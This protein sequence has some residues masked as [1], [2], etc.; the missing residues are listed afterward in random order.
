MAVNTVFNAIDKI[1]PAFGKMQTG[2]GRFS[3]AA[4]AAFRS[5][6]PEASRLND[7]IKGVTF[8]NLLS[9]GIA[10][11]VNLIRNNIK[12]A[13]GYASD[14]IEVQN[15]VDTVFGKSANV[16]DDF[17]KKAGKSFGLTELQAKKF[18]SNFGA[19]LSG[20]G[21][22]DK[23]A[24]DMSVNLTG[25]AGDLSSFFNLDAADAYS[26]L[27][28]GLMGKAQPLQSI[29]I[30]VSATSMEEFAK[31]QGLVWKS[32]D[33]ANQTML[34]YQFIMEKT[35]LA[36]GDYQKP[37]ASW[38]VSSRNATQAI[39]EMAGKLAVGFM[40]T[41]IKLADLV[42]DI[43]QKISDWADENKKFIAKKF[44]YYVNKL[45]TFTK[46]LVKITIKFGP[47]VLAAV[48]AV[49][50]FSKAKAI[51]QGVMVAVQAYNAELEAQKLATA[52]ATAAQH[53]LNT[54]MKANIIGLIVAGVV[55][56]IGLFI[57]LSQKVGGVKNAFIVV[58]QTFMK[59]ILTPFNFWIEVFQLLLPLG[60][61]IGIILSES[62][63]AVGQTVWKFLLTPLNLVISSIS[64]LLGAVGKIPGATW[65]KD[66]SNGIKTFQNSMN[67]LLTG[68][69]STLFNSGL[70]AFLDPA[71]GAKNSM[72]GKIQAAEALAT[73]GVSGIE[74]FQ[75]KMN[76]MLTGSTSTL[77][78][79]GPR[80]ITEPYRNARDAEIERRKK[81][82]EDDDPMKE[83]NKLLNDMLGK[84]DDQIEATH[85]LADNG[86]G[87]SPARLR[88]GAMGT[89]DFWEIQRLGI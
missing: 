9:K 1:T 32:M 50:A 61:R 68:S 15:V 86:K 60:A 83:T 18:S 72:A 33:R 55:L 88:W 52:G 30:D 21:I 4:K 84:F 43:A 65:A 14:L 59:W 26:K 27:Q 51:Y 36:Q 80:F 74:T 38:A 77:F 5:V 12:S 17:A 22:K 2:V 78:S 81:N 56:L 35:K 63:K 31:A 37:I 3:V 24:L 82:E 19:I 44:E 89:E 49:M 46:E 67:T 16:I 23:N 47:A 76:V 25:L 13:V 40:P 58:G 85:D 79:D 42:T 73:S 34:R 69:D 66:A 53:G 8:G 41:L 11:G 28:S 48:A 20:I 62:F 29:G 7:I 39:G 64:D 57:Q 54:A 70:S 87:S 10:T 6:I 75:D 71:K 45:I